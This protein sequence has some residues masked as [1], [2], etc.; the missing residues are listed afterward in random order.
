MYEN[1][2]IFKKLRDHPKRYSCP[3]VNYNIFL[4]QLLNVFPYPTTLLGAKAR[5]V[6]GLHNPAGSLD[7]ETCSLLE[8]LVLKRGMPWS[9]SGWKQLQ[10]INQ[11]FSAW[12]P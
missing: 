7:P 5:I 3:P 1:K 2:I 10:R 8:T 6:S 12:F 4:G 11:L 9:P